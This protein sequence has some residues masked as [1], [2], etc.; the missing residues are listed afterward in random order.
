MAAAAVVWLLLHRPRRSVEAP[1][2]NTQ[3]DDG[4]LSLLAH[5]RGI[6]QTEDMRGKL[7]LITQN[8]FQVCRLRGPKFPIIMIS[9]ELF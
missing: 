8:I 7:D 9:G 2:L 4:P 6:A 5:L 1:D 3:E